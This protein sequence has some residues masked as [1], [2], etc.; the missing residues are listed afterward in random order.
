MQLRI[1][2]ES[3]NVV[4]CI[5]RSDRLEH[6]HGHEILGLHQRRAQAHRPIELAVVVLGLPGLAPGLRRVEVQR[7]II[8]DGGGTEPFLQSRRI[9]EWLEAGTRLAEGLGH[10]IE[11]VVVK[12][13]PADQRE[14][15]PIR[16]ANR[17]ER[18]F[19]L[20]QLRDLPAT[21]V[22]ATHTDDRSAP[23]TGIHCRLIGK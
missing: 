5:L 4:L 6:A 7:R 15:R 22:I 23:D 18:R 20:W 17:D 1:E 21:L 13:E 14:N 11:L 9:D 19:R 8:D 12:I 10:V 3:S 16:R 2:A